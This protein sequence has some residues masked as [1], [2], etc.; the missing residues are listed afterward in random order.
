M[1]LVKKLMDCIK[2]ENS[3]QHLRDMDKLGELEQVFPIISKMKI[4]GECKFHVIN[5]F[6]HSI[7][8]LELLEEIMQEESFFDT[9]IKSK[10]FE[11]LNEKLDNGISKKELIKLGIF[12]HDMGKPLAQTIDDNG[13]VHFKKHEVL[14]ANEIFKIGENL[15]L[16]E[17]NIKILYK[18]IRYHMTLLEFYKSNNMGQDKLFSVFDILKN[19]SIDI[20]LIGYA[21]IVSTRKLIRPNEDTGVIKSY[22]TYGITNYLYRYNRI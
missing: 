10:V 18:Y 4:V 7:L 22:M 5:C 11:S 16:S 6:E 2:N 1:T 3:Y 21:D 14:G 15:G 20:F 8:A 19:E 13:R 9:H 12:L 17:K